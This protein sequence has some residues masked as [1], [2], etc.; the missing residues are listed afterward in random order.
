MCQNGICRS[1]IITLSLYTWIRRTNAL[2]T[3]KKKAAYMNSSWRRHSL[4]GIFM[5]NSLCLL[6][7]VATVPL[8]LYLPHNRFR[9]RK[10]LVEMSNTGL[11]TT[12]YVWVV[13]SCMA[14]L[15]V[16][17]GFYVPVWIIGSLTI[18]GKQAYAYFGS[19]RRCN[20]PYYDQ[21][22]PQLH[23]STSRQLFGL[24]VSDHPP[25]TSRCKYI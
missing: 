19:F 1:M 16:V 22:G 13:L 17:T 21:V 24:S 3:V 8:F 25:L 5:F 4:L 9:S 15:C 6:K 7:R 18:D 11:T 10:V 14:S 23:C 12:G 20:Y 2:V